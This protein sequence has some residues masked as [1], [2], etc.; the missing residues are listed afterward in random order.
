[1]GAAL[2]RPPGYGGQALRPSN[3]VPNVSKKLT[4][5]SLAVATHDE[6]TCNERSLGEGATTFG[7]AHWL[8]FI[9]ARPKTQ[10]NTLLKTLFKTLF[11][12]AGTCPRLSFQ[13]KDL[14]TDSSCGSS[15][16][17]DTDNASVSPRETGVESRKA[18]RRHSPPLDFPDR[19]GCRSPLV[20][21]L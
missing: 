11:R 19:P 16:A 13:S 12:A 15:S 20:R 21:I 6:K 18:A 14:L 2:L 10:P 3:R 8:L 9:G 17:D 4:L 1:M 5:V 7:L